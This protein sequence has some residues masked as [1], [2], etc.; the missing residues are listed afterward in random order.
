MHYLTQR[1]IIFFMHPTTDYPDYTDY[2]DYYRLFYF[3]IIRENPCNPWA[4]FQT[5]G[6]GPGP[7]PTKNKWRESMRRGIGCFTSYDLKDY[8]FS[9]LPL[10][11]AKCINAADLHKTNTRQKKILSVTLC[12]FVAKK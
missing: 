3:F 9:S 2:N 12:N 8:F 11:T 5:V 1:L 4:F 10:L 6:T 7:A